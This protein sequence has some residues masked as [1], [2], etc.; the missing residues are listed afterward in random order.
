[1]TVAIYVRVSTDKQD[2]SPQEK[3]LV[4]RAKLEGKEHVVFRDLGFSGSDSVRR[5]YAK[6]KRRLAAGEFTEVWVTKLD[7]LGRSV[8]E[9]M[10]FYD[11]AEKNGVRVVVT[12]QG[13]DTGTPAGRLLRTMLAAIAEFERDLIRE[14][15][16]VAMDL[17]HDGKKGTRS[18]R[19]VGRPMKVTPEKL[20]RI[21]ELRSQ[22]PPV[23][24]KE[25]SQQ[26]GLNRGTCEVV[27]S[28]VRQ[29]INRGAVTPSGEPS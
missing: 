16:Q 13:I 20:E 3:R 2:L 8:K 12:D 22:V 24:W 18:G 9:L 6:L 26:V 29:F 4:D 17:I 1:V 28:R 7:R 21:H 11:L 27:Y 23:P 19:P 5:D 10:E 14:R 25:V 15:I